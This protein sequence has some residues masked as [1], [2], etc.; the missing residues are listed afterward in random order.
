V[1]SEERTSYKISLG[2]R[3]S[4][5]RTRLKLSQ[6]KLAEAI[7]T[8]ARSISRW[9]H[10]QAIPQQYYQEK[11][12]Q[13]LQIPL[14]VLFGFND[15]AHGNIF[16]S[17]PLWCVPYARNAYFT[18]RETVLL[19]LHER[20]HA[21]YEMTLTWPQ[22]VSGLGGIGKT[23][24]ALE[25][26]Y[27]F[28]NDYQAVMWIR[29]E[30][31]ETLVAD[32]QAL[33]HLLQLPETDSQDLSLIVK[34]VKRKLH[35][36]DTWLFICD[37]AED[38]EHVYTT[39]PDAS[40]GHVVLT[41]R[42]QVTGTLGSQLDLQK[43]EPAESLLFLLR[44][45]K[46]LSLETS[47]EEAPAVLRTQ[48]GVVAEVVDGHPLALD[49][50]GAYIDETKCSFS[51]YLERYAT[52]QSILLNER[53]ALSNYHS[54]SVAETL[55]CSFRAVEQTSP[56]AADLLR[57]C[58][59]LYPDA[60]PEELIIQ[61]MAEP[62]LA[63]QTMVTDPLVLDAA[64]KALRYFSLLYREPEHKTFTIHRLT[65]AIIKNEMDTTTRHRWAEH[66][67]RVLNHIFPNYNDATAWPRCQRY[68]PH[69]LNCAK[70]I[71]EEGIASL[72]AGELL[73]RA[74]GYLYKRGYYI[75]AEPILRVALSIIKD[76]SGPDY[77]PV[78]QSCAGIEA[79]FIRE[80]EKS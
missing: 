19:Q 42:S 65:Q 14:D 49:Q 70:F 32:Y 23:Q 25:Y 68:L 51:E 4:Q 30:T 39:L 54:A 79:I 13:V 31:R 58:S 80:G 60:I 10:N 74:G 53:G 52:R 28:R 77:L 71:E 61:G 45:A 12:C 69:I 36:Y 73:Y 76:A 50:A 64:I 37:G 24:T 17:T 72:E 75:Q 55:S 63:L 16:R 40:Q 78:M 57:L 8:T 41:T 27:R 66:T 22:V 47:P 11:L 43:M 33:A 38:L 34:A 5:L 26:A 62:D 1:F 29:A 2:Q 44:R 9:E 20:L 3:L 48:A 35:S 59:F 21:E 15:V 67:I 7:G 46:Y 6:E 18:G 56:V